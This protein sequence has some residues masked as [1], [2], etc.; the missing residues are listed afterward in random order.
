MGF[1]VGGLQ[2]TAQ[3][4]VLSLKELESAANPKGDCKRQTNLEYLDFFAAIL[5][6]DIA[7]ESEWEGPNVEVDLEAE[8]GRE[9]S[10]W[11]QW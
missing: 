9:S 11:R 10:R 8:D 7:L 2:N 3:M 5:F 1:D 4:T 6:L